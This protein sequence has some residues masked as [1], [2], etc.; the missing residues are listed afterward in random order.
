MDRVEQLLTFSK[1]F[2]ADKSFEAINENV[3]LSLKETSEKGIRELQ[4]ENESF[5]QNLRV[6][7]QKKQMY[8]KLNK[9]CRANVLYLSQLGNKGHSK[10]RNKHFFSTSDEEDESFD[11]TVT[12]FENLIT[13]LMDLEIEFHHF[14]K[15]L[16]EDISSELKNPEGSEPTKIPTVLINDLFENYSQLNTLFRHQQINMAAFRDS[17]EEAAKIKVL[18]IECHKDKLLN[19]LWNKL[20]DTKRICKILAKIMK[21][22]FCLYGGKVICS[23]DERIKRNESI[24]EKMSSIANR[25]FSSIKMSMNLSKIKSR[26]SVK[27]GDSFANDFNDI[28]FIDDMSAN[29]KIKY[30]EVR[31]DE[32][33]GPPLPNKSY[34]L[35][36]ANGKKYNVEEGLGKCYCAVF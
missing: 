23:L 34:L 20:R 10:M 11:N 16:R 2:L 35:A 13:C 7:I 4:S 17:A 6:P 1:E 14:V 5:W 33:K 22:C 15:I 27:F 29:F 21:S 36:K 31:F 26:R 28:F 3:I 30:S 9:E 25:P 32:I 18:L 19:F 24:S 8:V 12:C